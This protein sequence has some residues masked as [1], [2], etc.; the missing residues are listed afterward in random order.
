[1][2]KTAIVSFGFAFRSAKV[3]ISPPANDFR[4]T[5]L[6]TVGAVDFQAV[7]ATKARS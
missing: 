7:K 3:A 4:Q 1:M 6:S 5:D 2:I